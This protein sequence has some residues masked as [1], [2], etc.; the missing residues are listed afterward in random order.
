VVNRDAF[1]ADRRIAVLATLEP[2]G[3]PYLTAV[4]YLWRDG[5]F[6]IPTNA[7]SRKVRN[8]AARPQGSIAIDSR[9]EAYAGVSATGR[10]NVL[11]GEEALT[12]NDEIHYRF[13][14]DAG[15]RD[16]EVGGLLRE[17]DD[18]TL[19]LVPERWRSWDMEPVFGRRFGDQ[20][21]VYPLEP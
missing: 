10:I 2:D 21:L 17:G 12:L 20:Q 13:V 7:T 4:W 16:P 11:G 19:L 5:T 1:L 15:M 18:T 3:S 14:T 6:Y 9:G 8:A